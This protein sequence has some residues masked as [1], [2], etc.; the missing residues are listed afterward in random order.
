MKVPSGATVISL[1]DKVAQ[2]VLNLLLVI[3][4]YSDELRRR[5]KQYFGN[6]TL[7]THY[8]CSRAVNMSVI[9]DTREQGPPRSA[10]RH[11]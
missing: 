6:L 4:Y 7:G 10:G 9:L 8:P 1:V 2:K 5:A 3:L 11:K